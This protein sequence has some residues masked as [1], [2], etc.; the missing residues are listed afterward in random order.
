MPMQSP[1]NN[2]SILAACKKV[3][4]NLC[5]DPLKARQ[6]RHYQASPLHLAF[7]ITMIVV[8]FALV[9]VNI[10]LWWGG[11][12]KYIERVVE[13]NITTITPSRQPRGQS[14][15]QLQLEVKPVV[16]AFGQ[17][18][19]TGPHPPR[20]GEESTYWIF[21]RLKPP[22]EKITNLIVRGVLAPGV[23]WTGQVSAG[24]GYAPTCS[25]PCLISARAVAETGEFRWTIGDLA[26]EPTD[27]LFSS[28]EAAFEVAFTPTTE[29]GEYSLLNY[30]EIMGKTGEIQLKTVVKNI[31]TEG[32]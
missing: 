13:K 1:K 20:V 27:S 22:A 28:L 11:G 30:L 3:Y 8:M 14:N 23:R 25:E 31:T 26:A 7:D 4:G 17:T 24:T 5:V 21:M 18:I 19:S 16:S 6:E 10:F 9:A 32:L 29:A 2:Q 12:R 15:P